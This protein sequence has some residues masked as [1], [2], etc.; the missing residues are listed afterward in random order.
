MPLLANLVV[1]SYLKWYEPNARYEYQ[2]KVVGH[3]IKN[4]VALKA[5]LQLLIKH[6]WL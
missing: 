4:H 3:S 2:T 5:R 1:P 6:G